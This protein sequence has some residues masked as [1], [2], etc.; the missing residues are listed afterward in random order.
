MP[1]E[2]WAAAFT[3]I[4]DEG[5][6]IPPEDIPLAITLATQRPS[7]KRFHI[8]GMDGVLRHIEIACIPITGLQGDILGAAAFFWELSE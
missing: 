8:R 4:D 7:Y 1:L 5:Q 2:E 3:R 6:P